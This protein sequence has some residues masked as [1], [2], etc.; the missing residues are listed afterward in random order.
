MSAA[1]L[2]DPRQR[3]D[4]VEREPHIVGMNLDRQG[5]S[6]MNTDNMLDLL[7]RPYRIV[8]LPLWLLDA[9]VGG[10]QNDGPP[11]VADELAVKRDKAR[12]AKL[13]AREIADYEAIEA[14]WAATRDRMRRTSEAVQEQLR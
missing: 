8:R 2:L 3:F 9:V 4:F 7:R 13:E 14:A 5:P 6:A 10:A 11:Q 12:R 1:L